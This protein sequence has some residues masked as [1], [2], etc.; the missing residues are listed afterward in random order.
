MSLIVKSINQQEK[1]DVAPW[2]RCLP[3]A[4][5]PVPQPTVHPSEGLGE[6]SDSSC[7]LQ[8]PLLLTSF[9]VCASEKLGEEGKKTN[10]LIMGME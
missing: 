3:V 7:A 4:R 2:H 6:P 5:V 8:P 10:P 1:G 9:P